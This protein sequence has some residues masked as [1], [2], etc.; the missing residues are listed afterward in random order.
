MPS[1]KKLYKKVYSAYRYVLNNIDPDS[2]TDFQNEFLKS[3]KITDTKTL[4]I[5]YKLL[6]CKTETNYNDPIRV[7]GMHRSVYFW[8]LKCKYNRLAP[9]KRKIIKHNY[10]N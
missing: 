10:D 7:N 5:C 4:G 2:D 6:F 8:H 9:K 1:T 3:I